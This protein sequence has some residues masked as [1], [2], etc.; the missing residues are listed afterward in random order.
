[1][2]SAIPKFDLVQP[3]AMTKTQPIAN[4]FHYISGLAIVCFYK[5]ITFEHSANEL[6]TFVRECRVIVEFLADSVS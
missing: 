2:Y 1:M 5:V 4:T 6:I 3:F